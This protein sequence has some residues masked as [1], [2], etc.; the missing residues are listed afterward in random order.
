MQSVDPM[1][2]SQPG[3]YIVT[4]TSRRLCGHLSCSIVCLW[5][6]CLQQNCRL[7][8]ARQCL[9][10]LVPAPAVPTAD[11]VHSQCWSVPARWRWNPYHCSAAELN[12]QPVEL[13]IDAASLLAWCRELQNALV[14]VKAYSRYSNTNFCHLMVTVRMGNTG[15]PSCSSKSIQLSSLVHLRHP[16]TLITQ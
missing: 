7:S 3:Q 1:A 15:E 14:P 9:S 16:Y 11:R 5:Q 13:K 10:L 2:S 4:P 12:R 8:E 6:A